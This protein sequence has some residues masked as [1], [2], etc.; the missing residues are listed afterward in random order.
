MEETKKKI[1]ELAESLNTIREAVKEA[2]FQVAELA[3]ENMVLRDFLMEAGNELCYKCRRYRE[4]HNGACKDC[5]WKDVK[6]GGM[7]G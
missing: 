2:S 3:S 4:S 6:S 7:P 1:D 5:K